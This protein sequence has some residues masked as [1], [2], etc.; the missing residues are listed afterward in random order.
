MTQ[1]LYQPTYLKL[2][3]RPDS[4]WGTQWDGWYPFLGQSRDS[5][6]LERSNYRVALAALRKVEDPEGTGDE[7]GSASVQEEHANHYLCG[8]VETIMIHESDTAALEAADDMCTR[9]LH[10]PVLDEEDWSNLE[11]EEAQE[12][13]ASFSVRDRIPY[14]A[15]YG[16]S[17]FAARR[18][19][20]PR[21]CQ[22][23]N[24]LVSILV[25]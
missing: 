1:T 8:W 10:H 20:L 25:S 15:D 23:I 12:T 24:E 14:C 3:T 7:E 13:W 18:N 11:Y 6:A 4:Y 19:S 2:W 22:Q 21:D 16:A 9:L 17:I 5:D